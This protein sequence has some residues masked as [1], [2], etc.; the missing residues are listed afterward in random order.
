MA[1]N[2][3]QGSNPASNPM[4]LSNDVLH[5]AIANKLTRYLLTKGQHTEGLFLTPANEGEVNQMRRKIKQDREAIDISAHTKNPHVIAELLIEVLS[6]WVSQPLLTYALYDSF[7]LTA[8][9]TRLNDRLTAQHQLCDS[10]PSYF[11]ATVKQCLALLLKVTE[12]APLTRVTLEKLAPIFAPILL[13]PKKVEPY[14]AEQDEQRVKKLFLEMV[15]YHE[16]IIPQ[17]VPGETASRSPLLENEEQIH[18]ES[19]RV[20]DMGALNTIRRYKSA[21]KQYFEFAVK[22]NPSWSEVSDSP[23]V[24]RTEDKSVH[25]QKSR[26]PEIS[27]KGPTAPESESTGST[28][29]TASRVDESLEDDKLLNASQD[30][31]VSREAEQHAPVTAVNDD[32]NDEIFVQD[33]EVIASEEKPVEHHAHAELIADSIDRITKFVSEEQHKEKQHALSS[34]SGSEV[35][36]AVNETADNNNKNASDNTDNSVDNTSNDN[37]AADNTRDTNNSTADTTL[38]ESAVTEVVGEDKQSSDV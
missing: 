7:V 26:V 11:K 37:T 23:A 35:E 6:T 32:S 21:A 8:D 24:A 19:P 12:N 16:V 30:V 17:Q 13:R 25:E 14:M 18:Y 10:L 4:T 22:P 34:L 9:F 27:I 2:V 5:L 31:E 15:G 1:S 29:M 38:V 28:D 36:E 20:I 3:Q 33:E